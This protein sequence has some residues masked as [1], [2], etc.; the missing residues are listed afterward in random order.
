MIPSISVVI[1]VF[2]RPVEVMRAISSV[3]RQSFTDF[4]LIVVDDGS[5]ASLTEAKQLCEQ[6]GH[7][8]LSIS[9]RGAAAARNYG[10]KQ[11]RGEWL[12]FLD[13]DD[14][15]LPTKLERQL[16]FHREQT[17]LALS[18]C[19]EIWYRSGV[20]VNP[21]N[22][23]RM[24]DGEA[25]SASLERC[26]VSFSAVMLRRALYLES[27]GCDERLIVCEDYDLWIRL[28][29]NYSFGLLRE[30]L[31]EKFGGA[32]DQLSKSQVAIDR[33][34]VFSLLKNF[35]LLKLTRDQQFAL[36]AVLKKK[37]EILAAGATKRGEFERAGLYQR[38]VEVVESGD[39]GLISEM[40]E[41]L[42]SVEL[43]SVPLQ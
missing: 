31:V 38:I 18:Q 39:R 28:A 37:A 29:A 14:S 30:P 23:H 3:L 42:S 20:R 33:F 16:A 8:F 35:N 4:E 10:A 12:C 13:S 15:W 25:F 24:P 6:A 26:V 22:V 7:R 21:R 27:G 43:R 1:P 36:L 9:H 11:A 5:K 17:E 34:R 40:V 32:L 2:D 41:E 19:E